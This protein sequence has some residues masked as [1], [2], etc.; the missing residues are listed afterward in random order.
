MFASLQLH[1]PVKRE[2]AREGERTG[3]C[4]SANSTFSN[5]IPRDNEIAPAYFGVLHRSELYI[6]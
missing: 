4:S 2:T 3:D 5:Q 1:R 6:I